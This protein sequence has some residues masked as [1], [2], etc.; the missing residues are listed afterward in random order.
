RFSSFYAQKLPV[1]F[2]S[3]PAI[4][5]PGLNVRAGSIA[6]PAVEGCNS[7]IFVPFWC[8]GGNI[9]ETARPPGI[10]NLRPCRSPRAK[11]Y[12]VKAKTSRP[13]ASPALMLRI[14]ARRPGGRQTGG[15]GGWSV[16]AAPE[17]LPPA[18]SAIGFD[19][20]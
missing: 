20:A 10:A 19:M 15:P 5:Q 9:H 18:D 12:W 11:K 17:T 1:S 7:Y 6:V 2:R 13:D 3:A 4:R 8:V 14:P 16:E